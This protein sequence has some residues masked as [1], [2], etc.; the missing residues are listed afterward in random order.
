MTGRTTAFRRNG[1]HMFFFFL[2]LFA[3]LRGILCITRLLIVSPGVI[4]GGSVFPHYVFFEA[5]VFGG[6]RR[7]FVP[8]AWGV[9]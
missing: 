4:S 6:P 8:G 1:T 5:A 9:R 3:T 7:D 2:F